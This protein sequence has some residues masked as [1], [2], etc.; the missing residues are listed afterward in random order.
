MLKS[1]IHATITGVLLSFALPFRDGGE[2]SPSYKL[3][4]RLH[5]PVAFGVLP[6]FAFANTGIVIPA[7]WTQGLLM[8]NS[9]GIVFGLCFGKPI[10]ILSASYLL[11]ATGFSSLPQ[12]LSSR[13]IVGASIAA[14]IGFTMSIFV[15]N[16]AFQDNGIIDSC[17]IAILI[18]LVGS[19]CAGLLWFNL[20]VPVNELEDNNIDEAVEDIALEQ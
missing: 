19:V 20:F 18:S 16:L 12:G 10:G 4:H 9:L 11:V 15:T 2:E 13:H 17:K 3:Q 8:P 14:G 6:I 5:Y 1:G 7:E